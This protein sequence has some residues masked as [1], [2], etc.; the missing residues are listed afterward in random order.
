MHPFPNKNSE[1]ASSIFNSVCK[2]TIEL[3]FEN[4]CQQAAKSRA[5]KYRT[6]IFDDF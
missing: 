4:V 5:P 2:I 6:K 1:N 3:T